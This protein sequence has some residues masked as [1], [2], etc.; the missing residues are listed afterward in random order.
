M[1]APIFT[2]WAIPRMSSSSLMIVA[3]SAFFIG[4]L[5]Q[6]LA[7]VHQSYWFNTF[8]SFVVMAWGYVGISSILSSTLDNANL[9]L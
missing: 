8:W 5:L 6:A 7:P 3:S 2:A 4:S 9:T 1:V